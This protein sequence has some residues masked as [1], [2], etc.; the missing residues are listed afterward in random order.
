VAVKIQKE[1]V[2]GLRAKLGE[3]TDFKPWDDAEK[4][5]S[6]FMLEQVEYA[7]PF[8]LTFLSE[9]GGQYWSLKYFQGAKSIQDQNVITQLDEQFR[10]NQSDKPTWLSSQHS[11]NIQSPTSS[12]ESSDV[13]TISA[14]DI[15]SVL[16]ELPE[17]KIEIM[18]TFQTVNFRNETDEFWGLEPLVN[19]N[20]HDLFP[21]YPK[22]RTILIPENRLFI[23]SGVE[24]RGE[25]PISGIK[26]IPDALLIVYNRKYKT[27][28][29]INLIEYECY[30]E[31]RT[32]TSE[33]S[34][35]MN[36]QIIPQVMKFASSFSIVTDRQIREET[37]RKWVEKIIQYIFSTEGLEAKFTTWIREL[38]P[39]IPN[40]MIAL[41][42]NHLLTEALRSNLQ[43]ILMIDELSQEQRDTIKNVIEAFKLDT[44]E[45]IQFTAYVIRLG[46]K[47]SMIE[48]SAEF[49]LSVQ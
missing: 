10:A 12:A 13:E 49:S 26:S 39:T 18:G 43:I 34:N 19:S 1:T 30:G 16:V 38:D 7:T 21:A 15:T 42:M 25:K 22:A 27:P 23:S 17:E 14:E 35:Y 28:I 20:F 4:Y 2:C 36:G 48:Q 47:I 31:R 8:S 5:V 33:K 6:C 45:S 40:A 37:I 3:A 9:V 29:Q 44:G 11:S 41:R 32:R 46:Q 24:V